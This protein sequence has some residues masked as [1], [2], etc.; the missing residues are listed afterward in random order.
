[1]SEEQLQAVVQAWERFLEAV[2]RAVQEIVEAFRRLLLQLRRWKL[3][4][5]MMGWGVPGGLA[6]LLAQR[7]PERWLPMPAC[8][9]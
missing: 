9:P 1:M 4:E 2:R 3:Q 7:W 5:R 8:P 6:R